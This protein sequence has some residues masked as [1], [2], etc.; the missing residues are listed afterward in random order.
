MPVTDTCIHG[1]GLKLVADQPGANIS[2]MLF[3]ARGALAKNLPFRLA[4]PGGGFRVDLTQIAAAPESADP[5]VRPSLFSAYQRLAVAEMDN[6]DE[7]VAAL[8]NA[9][10]AARRP[11]WPENAQVMPSAYVYFGQ[12]LAHEVSRLYAVSGDSFVNLNTP[13]LDLDTVFW[14]AGAAP[15]DLDS[16]HAAAGA[17]TEGD[18]AIGLTSNA[19]TARHNELP[20]WPDGRPLTPD[21]RA[22]A[23]VFVAQMQVAFLRRYVNQVRRGVDSPEIDLRDAIHEIVIHDFLPR[24]V[25]AETWTDVMANGRRIVSP[26]Q[27]FPADFLLPIEFTAAAFR[28]GHAMARDRYQWLKAS[29]N[30]P[31]P[32]ALSRLL[33]NTFNGRNL[34]VSNG[35][36][37]LAFN[38]EADWSDSNS[39]ASPN[40][41]API[42]P[43]IAPSLTRI[44][45]AHVTDASGPSNI[46]FLTL[47]RG[48]V[49]ELPSAQ[50]LWERHEG[51]LPGRPLTCCELA[52]NQSEGIRAALQAGSPGDRLCCRTPLWFYVVRE[53]QFHHRGAKLGPLGGRI[54]MET[55]HAAVCAARGGSP[56]PNA[57]LTMAAIIADSINLVEAS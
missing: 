25:D 10:A 51:A 32:Q 44:D 49:V 40:V 23:N 41:A 4:R 24:I 48:Q 56:P 11:S 35:H 19:L 18:A 8:A 31:I 16:L 33:D 22:D 9:I 6:R 38:W 12:F 17:L 46:A 47:R 13:S 7:A 15:E 36:H 26:G 45:Q 42:A 1:G 28:F 52:E 34:V 39:P 2:A 37:V 55:L 3:D 5:S 14:R 53:A 54:V 57:G 50:S 21:C 43:A 29:S 20:R 30:P 27:G